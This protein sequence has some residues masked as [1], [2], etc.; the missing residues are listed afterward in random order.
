MFLKYGIY[1]GC[2]GEGCASNG[3]LNKTISF[4]SGQGQDGG[5]NEVEKEDEEI[6]WYKCA[7]YKHLTGKYPCLWNTQRTPVVWCQNSSL[8]G[9][10]SSPRLLRMFST[11]LPCLCRWRYS[12]FLGP[13]LSQFKF[14]DAQMEPM[15]PLPHRD[16]RDCLRSAGVGLGLLLEHGGDKEWKGKFVLWDCFHASGELPLSHARPDREITEG[17]GQAWSQ[18]QK[19]WGEIHCTQIMG[20]FWLPK[21][22]HNPEDWTRS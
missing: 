6:P 22:L 18:S 4:T 20:S 12:C 10:V 13:P 19:V 3:V 16:G 14:S 21:S 1:R 15:P 17:R 7:K 11:S 8:L 5:R 9:L 2:M